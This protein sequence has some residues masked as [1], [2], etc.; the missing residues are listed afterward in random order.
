[1][2]RLAAV[3]EQECEF[4]PKKPVVCTVGCELV[5]AKDQLKVGFVIICLFIRINCLITS[6]YDICMQDDLN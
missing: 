3:C 6:A 2:N 4:N 5:V 1:M